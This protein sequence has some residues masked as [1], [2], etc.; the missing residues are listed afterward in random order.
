MSIHVHCLIDS[1]DLLY[2]MALVEIVKGF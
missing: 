2:L 1:V